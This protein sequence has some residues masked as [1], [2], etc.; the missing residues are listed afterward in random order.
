MAAHLHRLIA[1]L[2]DRAE[3][4]RTAAQLEL[5]PKSVEPVQQEWQPRQELPVQQRRESPRQPQQP[6]QESP[7]RQRRESPRRLSCGARSS[8]PQRQRRD[9]PEQQQQQQQQQGRQVQRSTPQR[10]RREGSQREL[11]ESPPPQRQRR[12]SPPRQQQADKP[13]PAGQAPAGQ[14]LAPAAADAARASQLPPHLVAQAQQ[15]QGGTSALPVMPAPSASHI[16]PSFIILGGSSAA[17]T[18]AEAGRQAAAHAAWPASGR[19]ASSC[20]CRWFRGA[21]SAAG[22]CV[23]NGS[24]QARPAASCRY[25]PAAQRS[26]ASPGR[27]S[28]HRARGSSLPA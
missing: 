9:A 11:R 13:Q 7:R 28:R 23:V 2:E 14:Q 4:Q 5:V 3:L 21:R 12:E 8:S 24:S 26:T 25:Q 18:E 19:H 17:E 20:S 6:R 27:Y 22:G 15:Q 10:L 16:V 1:D